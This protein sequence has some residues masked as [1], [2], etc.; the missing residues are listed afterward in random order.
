MDDVKRILLECRYLLS[1]DKS[2]EEIAKYL[3]VK[4]ELVYQDIFRTLPKFD[5]T[6]YSRVQK[7]IKK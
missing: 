6:L 4:E 5:K 7:R 2:F 1:I 3:G